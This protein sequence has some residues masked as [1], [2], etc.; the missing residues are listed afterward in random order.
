MIAAIR[1]RMLPFERSSVILYRITDDAVEIVTIACG[2][3]D[4]EALSRQQ[5]R[6][7][8]VSF[9]FHPCGVAVAGLR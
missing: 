4:C 7:D 6:W 9:R 5:R 1:D 3:R 2:G 8:L